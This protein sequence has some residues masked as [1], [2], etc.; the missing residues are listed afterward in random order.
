MI[1]KILLWFC[2]RNIHLFKKDLGEIAS[3]V[4]CNGKSPHIYKCKTCEEEQKII[5]V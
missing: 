5:Y 4:S 3:A 1:K 2:R